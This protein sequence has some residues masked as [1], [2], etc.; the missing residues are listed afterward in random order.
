MCF[1]EV[2]VKYLNLMQMTKGQRAEGHSVRVV[3]VVTSFFNDLVHYMIRIL[4]VI[5]VTNL[6][7]LS[8]LANLTIQR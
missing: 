3:A 2:N 5:I 1:C 8:N 7:L 6:M 4:L